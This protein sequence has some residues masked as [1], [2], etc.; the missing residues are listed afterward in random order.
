MRAATRILA[1]IL[2]A[3]FAIVLAIRGEL[4]AALMAMLLGSIAS[5]ISTIVNRLDQLLDESRAQSRLLV[6]QRDYLKRIAETQQQAFDRRRVA[7]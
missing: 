1:I 3:L 4:G 7:S 2:L 5:G 6:D